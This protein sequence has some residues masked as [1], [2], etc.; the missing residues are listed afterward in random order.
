MEAK[1]E[2][3]WRR[4]A[5]GVEI[6]DLEVATADEVVIGDNNAG[7]RGEEDGIGR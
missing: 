3:V 5:R 7:N 1:S 2:E 4:L 6:P